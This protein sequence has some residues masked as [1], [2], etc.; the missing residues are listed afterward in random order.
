MRFF[1]DPFS[2]RRCPQLWTVDFL[3]DVASCLAPGGLLATY[4]RS[5]AVRAALIEVG[6]HI[7]TV[8]I[9]EESPAHVWAQ[10]TL[11]SDRPD[12]LTPLSSMEQEHLQTRAGIALRD[13]T[14]MASADEILDGQSVA[15]AQSD[16]ES[17]SSWRRRWQLA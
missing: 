11:A 2:P 4:S 17:T 7:G 14:K 6:L 15:Q 5:A 9:V 8:P 13:P 10:G 16:R 1:L 3:K 12:D